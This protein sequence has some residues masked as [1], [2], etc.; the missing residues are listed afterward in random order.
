ML[1]SARLVLFWLCQFFPC[2]TFT[3]PCNNTRPHMTVFIMTCASRWQERILHFS[4]FDY[5]YIIHCPHRHLRTLDLSSCSSLPFFYLVCG[6]PC[7]HTSFAICL[8]N[9]FGARL[10]STS[11]L[12]N[13][14][15]VTSCYL[16]ANPRRFHSSL[17]KNCFWAWKYAKYLWHEAKCLVL[18][19][20]FCHPKTRCGT[21]FPLQQ[22]HQPYLVSCIALPLTTLR[23]R[24]VCKHSSVLHNLR[25]TMLV[26]SREKQD[27]LY[28][29][30]RQKF[31][32]NQ[33][34]MSCFCIEILAPHEVAF[35][36]HHR[37]WVN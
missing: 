2:C 4:T 26:I 3:A 8:P 19:S 23:T 37:T 7:L 31:K 36:M 22:T 1:L 29:T 17:E 27:S 6:I 9:W 33:K 32:K 13:L 25:C 18:R 30:Q 12:H 21:K 24:S 15:S 10:I 11:R 28:S 14:I 5:T 35:D 16:V 20:F 34:N